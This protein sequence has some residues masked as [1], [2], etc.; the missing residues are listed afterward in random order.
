MRKLIISL[1]A[2]ITAFPAFSQEILTL[3]Q[4][5]ELALQNNM[6]M[7]NAV[8]SV[9]AAR[10][11]KKE[12]FTN[13]FPSVSGMGA[14]V[15]LSEPLMTTTVETGA[16]APN[17]K[18]SVEM[19]K[20]NLVA[21][22][23]LTQPV[24]AGGQIVNGNRLAQA[25]MEASALQ[26]Q[27]TENET[28][29]ATERYF[30]QLVSLK[31]KIVTIE[32]SEALLDRV[33]RDV[34]IAVE[35]G[36][37]IRN[38]LLR[39]ELERNRLE[40]GKSKALNGL[41]ILK[42]ALAQHIG[43]ES[44]DFDVETPDFDDNIVLPVGGNN[45]SLLHRPEYKLLEKSVD[46]ARLQRDME[47]GKR[48]PTV[49]VGAGYNWTKMDW[50]RQTESNKNFGMAF[51]TVS[52]PLTDWWGGSHAIKKKKLELQQ[53]ENTRQ[54][55]SGLLLL[56]MKQIRNELTEAYQQLLIAKKSIS[57]ARE[58]VRTGEDSYKNGLSILSD[59]LDAQNLLQQS[60]DQYTEAV[61]EYFIKLAEY[62]QV[63][64]E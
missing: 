11:S 2:G 53:A 55:K 47:I 7:Q 3:Q 25:G 29:L 40:S 61:T 12:A 64:R 44:E 30:W 43:L 62:K 20:N 28:L 21:G 18:V 27:M 24:F 14:G 38:D 39:V 15:I 63:M 34:S 60:R 46:I 48:L 4:C 6:Q 37:T 32:N 51:A 10:Q 9:E 49:A 54:D 1:L 41:N 45:Y 50:K 58:N 26:R 35:A 16:P 33:Y 57:V 22:V 59:L 13:Y 42:A 52:V 17:D 5:R 23:T 36:L 56:Q 8:L 31:E 19:I